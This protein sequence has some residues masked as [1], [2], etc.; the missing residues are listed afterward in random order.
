MAVVIRLQGLPVSAG[1]ADIRHFFMG[2]TVP[3]GGVHIIGGEF[4]EAYIIFATDDDARCAMNRS[5]GF[6]KQ[7][8]IQ[9]YLSSKSEMQSTIE[10]NRNR[11][12]EP[13]PVTRGYGSTVSGATGDAKFS[14]V[15]APFKRINKTG[16][17]SSNCYNQSGREAQ[18]RDSDD[19]YL[20][21]QGLP[22]SSD[23]EEVRT[24]FHGLHVDEIIFLQHRSGSFLGRKNGN[25]LV[26]FT[27]RKDAL[28]GLKRHKQ[29]IGT[30]FID[31]SKAT[32]EQWKENSDL[33]VKDVGH[34]DDQHGDQSSSRERNGRARSRSPHNLDFYVHIKNMSNI[35]EKK[36][37]KSFF[38]NL[39]VSDNQI[40]FLYNSYNRTKDGFIQ[41]KN[42]KDYR[43]ALG[44]HKQILKNRM[45]Y[46]YPIGR[47][48]MLKLIENQSAQRGKHVDEYRPG[49]SFQ[50]TSS[51]PRLYIYIRNFPFDVTKSEVRKFFVGFSLNDD[52]IYL[53]ND[54]NEVG[55]GE[56]LV[57]FHSEELVAHAENLNHRRFLGTEVLLQRISEAQLK[58][59]GVN[60]F[61]GESN[62]N[63]HHM[64]RYSHSGSS[65]APSVQSYR[66]SDDFRYGPE[67]GR[68]PPKYFRGQHPRMDFSGNRF[69]NR[70]NGMEG[71]PERRMRFDDD[72]DSTGPAVIQLI[73]IPFTTTVDE[74]LDFFYGY[75]VIPD[76]VS[77][78]YN[79][80][81]FATGVATIAME[82]AR[83]AL[84]AI[85]ELNDRPVGPR[86]IKLSLL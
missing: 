80:S 50:D 26:K 82:N 37:V 66:A 16:P 14:N 6:I 62:D 75:R 51:K 3:D 7:S 18:L 70:N 61:P 13:K 27:T 65:H 55:L 43:T 46:I 1:S 58:E 44:L 2:L 60:P 23:E 42:E 20:F 78:Q 79:E 32:K 36:D 24:F 84:A 68:V 52:D 47:K 30:R 29:Y 86:K 40:R 12:R 11:G 31:I 69:A 81:G 67:E 28:E 85:Q 33:L 15:V 59:F 63:V 19:L 64:N 35:V 8:R 39:D 9:L 72:G 38:Q 57:M 56:A 4:G 10:M 49:S 48:S 71:N 74:I 22:Y 45:V 83:E 76:S 25:S 5:E 21:L 73:N 17:I 34:D 41:F 53:L 54:E 77:I